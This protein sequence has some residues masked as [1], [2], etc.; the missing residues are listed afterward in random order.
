MKKREKI[1]LIFA[2]LISIIQ[3]YF[4]PS[5]GWEHS[6]NLSLG[7]IAERDIVSP[8][9][10]DVYKS[11][12]QL[13][14][15]RKEAENQ[16]NYVYSISDDITYTALRNLDIIFRYFENQINSQNPE[17]LRSELLAKGYFLST[18]TCA[19][20]SN[21]QLR[22]N[23]YDY[24]TENI[25]R[26]FEIGIYPETYSRS[27]ISIKRRNTIKDYDLFK[28]YSFKEAQN[29][30]ISGYSDT[31]GKKA[32]TELASNV[33]VVNIIPVQNLTEEEKQQTQI[34]VSSIMGK[35]LKNETIIRKGERVREE[36][37][38]V[39]QSL[40]K[41]MTEQK[42][43]KQT[44]AIAESAIGTFLA[45][46]LLMVMFNLFIKST[47]VFKINN[48]KQY[49]LLLL[50]FF[51]VSL[52][53]I[54]I[55]NRF[56]LAAMMLPL[57]FFTIV[58]MQLFNRKLAFLYTTMQFFLVVILTQGQ[59]LHPL[60][61]TL[62][63]LAALIVPNYNKVSF[64]YL[65]VSIYIM[66]FL[67]I[68]ILGFGLIQILSIG[69][70]AQVVLYGLISVTFSSILAVSLVPYLEIRFGIVTRQQLLGL[71]NLENPLLKRLLIEIPGTYH[72]SLVVGN[73]AE[74]AAEAIGANHLLARVG[75]Y[76]HDIGK[77]NNT[78]IFIENNPQASEIHDTLLPSQSAYT[79]RKHVKDGIDLAK[80]A[81]L[82]QQII[83][84]IA[85]HHGTSIIKY[86]RNKAVENG[87][88]F[89]ESEFKY[90]GPT[91]QSRE[92]AIVMI[93]DIVESHSKALS[94]INPEIIDNLLNETVNKLL[95][96]G[97]LA[98]TPLTL[99]DMTLIIK[100]MQPI[101]IGVY[102]TRIEYP[103]DN[104]KS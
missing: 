78:R 34:E 62:A 86:F 88:D 103:E 47:D 41:A 48:E 56:K 55:S 72:H 61:L 66:F 64:R 96:D 90:A 83:D 92:A 35:V 65:S 101:L 23:M 4:N 49:L 3:I 74:S 29:K 59:F 77:L 52:F 14:K 53:T 17:S 12:A 51:M 6:V 89:D 38:Q 33:L 80:K 70:I 104:D 26:I 73:L 84:I 1:I 69:I 98:D 67:V 13:Y 79:I 24:I 91:P 102:S 60:I 100:A 25:A 54:F 11:D 37:L 57:S 5:I 9:E 93:A 45:I 31:E 20:L 75:S 76:Y 43:R 97:Q 36:E 42:A 32:I 95:Q 2:I 30:L 27:D 63:S 10:F 19:Y 46:L 85:Q 71:L 40:Q 18:E 16:G 81:A 50:L 82:P 58:V 87:L 7:Q 94:E 99:K 44:P 28:L 21:Q 15:E 68:F 22:R 39:L 8:I